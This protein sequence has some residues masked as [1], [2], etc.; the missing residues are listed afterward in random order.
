M[1]ANRNC[2]RMELCEHCQAMYVVLP[3]GIIGKCTRECIGNVERGRLEHEDIVEM[4][5]DWLTLSEPPC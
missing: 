1:D 3:S 5:P 2:E 4:D